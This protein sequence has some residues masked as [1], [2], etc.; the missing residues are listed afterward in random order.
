MFM[1][2]KIYRNPDTG[3]KFLQ[4]IHYDECKLL[5][6]KKNNLFQLLNRIVFDLYLL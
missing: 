1:V 2:K 4:I 6:E 5:K 3:N